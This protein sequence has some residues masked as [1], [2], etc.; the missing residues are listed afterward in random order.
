VKVSK[1]LP[2]ADG[3]VT[4]DGIDLGHNTTGKF[5]ADAALHIESPALTATQLPASATL[6]YDV[7]HDTASDFSGEAL[8]IDNA[9]ALTAGTAGGVSATTAEVRLPPGTNRYIRFKATTAGT[10]GDCSGAT[11][12]MRLAF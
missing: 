5:L 7:Y 11:A 3:T 1:A 2:A 9:L 12:T 8:L 10:A 6:A 4:S